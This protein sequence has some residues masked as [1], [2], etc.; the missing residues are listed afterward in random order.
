AYAVDL[1]TEKAEIVR[2]PSAIAARNAIRRVWTVDLSPEGDAKIVRE[3]HWSGE[4]AFDAR[5]AY[6]AEGRA[7]YEKEV[8]E[9]FRKMD[10]PGEVT[11]VELQHEN[12]PDDEFG[13]KVAFT[14]AGLVPDAGASRIVLSP[15]AAMR[16]ENPFTQT[17]RTEPIRLPYPNV[18]A[19]TVELRIPEGY[20][21]DGAPTG[22][23]TANDA[24]RYLVTV[25]TEGSSVVVDRLFEVKRSAA[26]ADAYP[27]YRSLFEAAARG[28]A[29][30]ALVL[31]KTPAV[32]SR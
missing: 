5:S 31:R 15:L 27:L 29:E 4:K 30:L 3:T 17:T 18:A 2:I 25:R 24:G 1:E 26:S 10:P 28:D 13:S 9:M 23:A 32:S 6:F 19:D 20:A 8:R 16:Q 14:R 11:S 7:E 12:D 22:F 21:L